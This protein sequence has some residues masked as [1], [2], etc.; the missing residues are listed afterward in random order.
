MKKLLFG[1]ILISLCVLI[2]SCLKSNQCDCEIVTSNYNYTTGEWEEIDRYFHEQDFDDGGCAD[3]VILSTGDFDTISITHYLE[4]QID[5]YYQVSP[6]VFYSISPYFDAEL[7][8]I[9]YETERLSG[10]MEE[11]DCPMY[12]N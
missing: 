8:F 10:Y 7:E 11:L 12:Y 2:S 9:D 1:F 5:T 4:G 6:G 3:R